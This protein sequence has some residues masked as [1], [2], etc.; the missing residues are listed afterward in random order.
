ME[1]TQARRKEESED[2]RAELKPLAGK[3][4]AARQSCQRPANVPSQAVH[5]QTISKLD[6]KRFGLV[7]AIEEGESALNA[8]EIEYNQLKAELRELEEKEV[9]EEVELDATAV[10]LKLY[11]ELGFQWVESKGS[12]DPEVLIRAASDEMHVV[13]LDGSLPETEMKNKLWQL[14]AL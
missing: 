1:E 3:L 14:N 8:K 11:E 4:A 7:K 13:K 10:R 6:D 12:A 2:M 9:T 5:A